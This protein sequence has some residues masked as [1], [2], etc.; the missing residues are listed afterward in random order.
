MKHG[1]A[2][3]NLTFEIDFADDGNDPAVT[4]IRSDGHVV[5]VAAENFLIDALPEALLEQ[6]K[7]DA[8]DDAVPVDD[9]HDVEVAS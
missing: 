2:T 7:A 9:G 1:T 8:W 3:I 5:D 4:A 6:L